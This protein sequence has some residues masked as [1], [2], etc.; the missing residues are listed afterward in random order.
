[1]YIFCPD[2]VDISIS[3]QT[4]RSGGNDAYGVR[5]PIDALVTL[6]LANNN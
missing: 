6:A 1:M 2:Y 5:L 3:L 4:S